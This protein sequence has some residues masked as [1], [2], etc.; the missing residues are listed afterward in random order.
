[1]ATVREDAR[2]PADLEGKTVAVNT[3]NNIGPVTINHWM[4]KHGGDYTKIK[5]VEVPFPDMG[6][7]LEA[8]RVDAA[9]TVE[10][11]YSGALDLEHATAR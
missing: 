2:T 3:L 5:Y 7:A 10:P 9:F 8:K 11:A 4:E 6:A 1:M